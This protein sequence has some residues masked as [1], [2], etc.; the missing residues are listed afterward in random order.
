MSLKHLNMNIYWCTSLEQ[1]SINTN[2]Y[3]VFLGIKY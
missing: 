1:S 3:T 2:K